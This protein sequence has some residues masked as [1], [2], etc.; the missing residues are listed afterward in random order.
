MRRVAGGL[1]TIPGES[2]SGIN[3][4]YWEVRA[5]CTDS[6]IDF[7]M[8]RHHNKGYFSY[9]C[10]MAPENGEIGRIIISPE[11]RKHR[12]GEWWLMHEGDIVDNYLATAISYIFTSFGS[13]EE[14]RV[15]MISAGECTQ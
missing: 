8:F 6:L 14:I 13:Q 5:K 7:P 15:E 11:I 9:K 10:I 3:W 1:Y 4:D 2:V 12:Y